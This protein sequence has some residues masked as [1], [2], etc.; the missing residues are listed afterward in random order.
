MATRSALELSDVILITDLASNSTRGIHPA[1]GSSIGFLDPDKK[2]QAIVKYSNGQVNRQISK[3]VR[4]LKANETI[5]A[6]GNCFCPLA[7]V[8]EQVQEEQ[9]NH[10]KQARWDRLMDWD[11]FRLNY[12]VFEI[13]P[14][15]AVFLT[16]LKRTTL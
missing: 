16:S 3:L 4:I 11:Q 7:E 1:L 14:E 2:S 6:I 13:L 5:P 8:D 9:E 15:T 10:I 12:K